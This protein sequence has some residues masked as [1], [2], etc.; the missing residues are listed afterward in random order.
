MCTWLALGKVRRHLTRRLQ[1]QVSH[2]LFGIHH[3]PPPD[4]APCLLPLHPGASPAHP[5]HRSCPRPP[6]FA[7]PLTCCGARRRGPLPPARPRP[8]TSSRSS[9]SRSSLRRRSS[10]SRQPL[11][12]Q[13]PRDRLNPSWPSSMSVGVG[14]C[15]VGCGREVR[16][17][18]GQVGKN[19]RGRNILHCPECTGWGL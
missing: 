3:L 4:P 15:V 12:C 17:G 8:R 10:S 11:R 1:V 19:R 6:T 13:V 14:G 16:G 2:G 9:V 5:K 18:S 7:R